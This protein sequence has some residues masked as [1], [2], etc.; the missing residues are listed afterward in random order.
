MA[1]AERERERES[2]S[3]RE[4]LSKLGFELKNGSNNVYQKHY[5]KCNK[6]LEIELK[7]DTSKSIIH[8]QNIEITC[9]RE[10][11]CD[12]HQDENKV[13]LECVNRLLNAGY[14][15]ENIILEKQYP[16][17][18][19]TKI[20]CDILIKRPNGKTYALIE[21][22]NVGN[23]YNE[24]KNA[25]YADIDSGKNKYGG[26]LFSYFQQDS[27]ADYLI[28]YASDAERYYAEIINTK[29]IKKGENQAIKFE[30]WDKTSISKGFFEAEP[31]GELST[32]LKKSDLRDI[33]QDDTTGFEKEQ[34]TGT[35]YNRFAEILRR[36]TISDKSNAYNKIFNLFL[37]KIV[38]EIETGDDEDLQFQWSNHEDAIDVLSRLNTLYKKGMNEYLQLTITDHEWNEIESKINQLNSNTR[39]ELKN[40]FTELRLYK[41]NE[42]AFQEVIDKTTFEKNAEIVEKVVKLLQPYKLKYSNKQQFLGDFFEK[43]LNVGIKQENGQFFTPVPIARFINY[44]IPYE[45]IIEE[46][47]NKREANCLP[48]VIDYA[49]GSGHFLTEA[50]DRIQKQIDIEAEK[51]HNNN[52]QNNLDDWKT[53]TNGQAY[54]WAKDFIFGI[55]K[56]YRLAKTTKIACFLNGDGDANIFYADGLA[57]FNSTDYSNKIKQGDLDVVVANPPYSVKC[58]KSVLQNKDFELY[59]KITSNS[60]SIECL[61]VER[62]KQLLK[63]GG[64]C[65]IILPS[66]ILTNGN[67][68]DETRKM[69]MQHFD[70]IGI[71]ELFENIFAS[72]GTTTIILFARRHDKTQEYTNIKDYINNFINTQQDFS[73]NNNNN[74]IDAYCKYTNTAKEKLLQ[75]LTDND[76]SLEKLTLFISNYNKK[77]V[78]ST[79]DNNTDSGKLG[80]QFIGFEY[81]TRKGHEGMHPYP[82]NATGKVVSQL[83]TDDNI[84]DD[85]KVNY[86]FY[87]AFRKQYPEIHENLKDNVKYADI[88][89]LFNFEKKDFDYAMNTKVRPRQSREVKEGY[90]LIENGEYLA[91]KKGTAI[92][93]KQ[94]QEGNIPVIAGGTKPAY[95]HNISNRDGNIIC[96][97]SSGSAGFVSYWNNPIFASD[98]FTIQSKDENKIIT[99]YVYIFLKSK[100]KEIMALKH[101]VGTGH[102]Y[103]YDITNNFH[104]PLPPLKTQQQIVEK[105]DEIEKKQ[106]ENKKK[107]TSNN[108]KIFEAIEDVGE[109]Q[110]YNLNE[111]C[112]DYYAGGDA[113]ENYTIN[114]TEQNTIPI[115]SNGVENDGLYGY[116]NKARCLEPA[117][118]ISAR[119]TIGFVALRTEPFV[120]IVRLITLIPNTEIVDVKLLYYIMQ[121]VNFNPNGKTIKQLTIPQIQDIKITIPNIEYQQSLLQ[122]IN[123][124]EKEND[125]LKNEID[126][127]EK[128]KQSVLSEYLK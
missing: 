117:I 82:D 106:D 1:I 116:T 57:S 44:C 11:T 41:N 4:F 3:L 17:G 84:L 15:P 109:K 46:K 40:I 18:R 74:V 38:D 119:G 95:Y 71:Q 5:S 123:Q 76:K 98:C 72:T 60:S 42:F 92:T 13:V 83:Y 12:F 39:K 27:D 69:F 6:T 28:L 32:K 14:L 20:W 2:N 112:K 118:T 34:N 122:Q 75:D 124:I 73:Y 121:K 78:I 101:G 77:C 96:I 16:V 19:N 103:D 30:L 50:M 115:Y 26:Q 120:P 23:D 43:L 111:F 90:I 114:K 108:N 62:T 22:K 37:C 9:N 89:D 81:S 87:N 7:S 99:K 59:D 70:L 113:P 85:K 97:S 49:C 24:A 64:M 125:D 93:S 54:R 48:K 126:L 66:S 68:A 21:C 110:E 45:N 100:Q 79:Y 47:I 35:I 104:F 102:V 31:Y 56:D 86:Y 8:Y 29:D 53:K 55:E 107:I 128:Q 94:V 91:I 80:K 63:E 58:F 25:L 105:F 88:N 33:T 52:I 127:L 65:G 61:F 10:T 51:T 67:V 36:Y